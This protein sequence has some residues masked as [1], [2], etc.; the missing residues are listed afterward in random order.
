MGGA[1]CPRADGLDR[2]G[3][4]AS[5][6]GGWGLAVSMAR[7]AHEA[8]G[9]GNDGKPAHRM[10]A[11]TC[12]LLWVDNT[13]RLRIRRDCDRPGVRSEHDLDGVCRRRWRWSR[14]ERRA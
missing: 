14:G 3:S 6:I 9:R 5:N 1:L 2:G 4:M 10:A 12:D 8:L 7:G 11:E 13:R